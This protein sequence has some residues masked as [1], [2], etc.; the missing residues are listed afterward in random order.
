MSAQLAPAGQRFL[1]EDVDWRFYKGVLR[2]GEAADELTWSRAVRA[3]AQESL[4]R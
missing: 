4:R 3:W 1:F 2:E